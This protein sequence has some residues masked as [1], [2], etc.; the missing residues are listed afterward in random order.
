LAVGF[1]TIG[2]SLFY[3]LER[4]IYCYHGHPATEAMG[5]QPKAPKTF[6]YLNPIGDGIHN[7][8]DGVISGYSF[9]P[10]FQASE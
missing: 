8:F 5:Q 9:P 1:V 4:F 7:L 10:G 3:F 2:F 6:V